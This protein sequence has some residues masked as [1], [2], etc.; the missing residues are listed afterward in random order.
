MFE[1]ILA[2]MDGSKLAEQV[3]PH[4]GEL[5]QAF[6]SEVILISV[7]EPEE[8]ESGQACRMYIYTEA[9]ILKE[10]T[11]GS[12]AKI[13]TKVVT[14]KADKTILGYA[15]T[16]D[17]DLVVMTSHGRSGIMP[18][19]LGSTVT[20]V[21]HKVGVPLIVIRAKETLT[22]QDKSGLFHRVLIPLDGSERAE[23]VLPYVAE[24]AKKID[25]EI[26]LV[27]VVE[28][29]RHVHSVGGI[30]YVR[31]RDQDVKRMK[32]KAMDYLRKVSTQFAGTRAK[33][34]YEVREGNSAQEII[35]LANEKGCSLI[36]LS[37]HGH[38]G[39]EAWLVGSVTY[40]IMQASNRSVLFVPALET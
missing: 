25:S 8:T 39:I 28:A 9:D 10:L 38:S 16:Q 2:P 1:K 22:E 40:K 21:L 31:F 20:K 23:K 19:S 32:D 6:N 35:K 33:V 7:C 29:G 4:V 18:W 37:S 13:K 5:A 15:E 12:G 24:I 14:G 3:I 34:S 27:Q 30:N 26:I 17:I 36:A 11:V